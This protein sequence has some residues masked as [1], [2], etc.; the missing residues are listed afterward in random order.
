MDEYIKR[1]DAL[2]ALS[3]S[4]VT[5]NMRA[6]K[7]VAALPAADVAEV[8]HG[9]WIPK[10][11]HTYMP[12]EYDENG[13]PILHRYT[14]YYCSLCGREEAKEEPYCHCGARMDKEDEHEQ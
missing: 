9:R 13:A 7:I 10:I 4:G 11:N 3:K 8:R 6:H 2:T 1:E 5:C 14:S 12:V